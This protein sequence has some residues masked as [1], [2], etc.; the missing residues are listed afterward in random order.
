M[1]LLV[2]IY[3]ANNSSYSAAYIRNGKKLITLLKKEAANGG[4]LLEKVFLEI[5]QNL[6]ERTCARVSFLIKL[7]GSGLQ[8][9]QKKR[10]AQVFSCELG[11]ISKNTFFTEHLRLLL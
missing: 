1:L 6:Q 11:E 5:L 3:V 9:H 10:L 7:L 4:V 2:I 8:L